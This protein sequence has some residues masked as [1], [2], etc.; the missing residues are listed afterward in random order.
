[1]RPLTHP[2][3]LS[4]FAAVLASVGWYN[5]VRLGKARRTVRDWLQ[6]KGWTLVSARLCWWPAGPFSMAIARH[7][8]VYRVLV[9][10]RDGALRRGWVCCA[11][12]SD[13]AEA[14]WEEAT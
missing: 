10:D 14:A 6:G 2:V 13:D 12:F 11:P 9:R 1:M 8:P 3:W 5:I 4:L 7:L